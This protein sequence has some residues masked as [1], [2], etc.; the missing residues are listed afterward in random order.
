MQT[1]FKKKDFD[2]L[3]YCY[4]IPLHNSIKRGKPIIEQIK[5]FEI[6]S[7]GKNLI[8]TKDD[9]KDRIS[10]D[11][12]I[13]SNN[14]GYLAFPTEKDAKEYLKKEEL[15]LNINSERLLCQLTFEQVSKIIEWSKI[16]E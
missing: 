9:N 14:Y 1:N 6:E 15:I 7:V 8:K 4:G 5:K 2:K 13:D 10:I 12:S 3:E 11:G 16:N